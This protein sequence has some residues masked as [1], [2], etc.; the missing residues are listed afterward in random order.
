MIR[1]LLILVVALALT[2]CTSASRP[3]LISYIRN[4]DTHTYVYWDG[5]RYVAHIF[6]DG[7]L[8]RTERLN[9]P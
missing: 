3:A 1:V 6:K 5:Y 4:G 7:V 2:G 8:V 9:N